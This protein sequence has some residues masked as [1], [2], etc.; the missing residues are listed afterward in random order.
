MKYDIFISY[1]RKDTAVADR[2]CAALDKAG[3]TYF[4]DRQGI[5]GGFE[6]PEVLAQGIMNSKLVLF[7]ASR[8]SY[9]SKCT[10]NEITFAFNEK[11][12]NSLL[13]Y[14]IDGST[15]PM[16]F[17][18]SFAGINCRTLESHP[19]D[20]VLI[21]DLFTL[22][23][24]STI[25]T[26]T[27]APE[28]PKTVGRDDVFDAEEMYRSGVLL[29]ND[30]K[31]AEAVKMLTVAA[32]QGH[33]EA[34]KL[35]GNFYFNGKGVNKDYSEAFKWSIKS[36]EQGIARAQFNVGFCYQF[37]YG[38]TIDYE[39]SVN[40]YMKAAKQGDML[41]QNALG[42]CY[43]NGKGVTRDYAMAVEWT[44]KAAE[45]GLP[46]AQFNLGFF[47]FNGYGVT[48]NFTE[49]INWFRKSAEQGNADAQ[50]YLGI[51]Y[52]GGDGVERSEFEAVKWFRKAAEQG[53]P[54][55]QFQLGVCYEQA[56]G[57]DMDIAEAAKWYKKAAEQGDKDAIWALEILQ[58]EENKINDKSFF[59]KITSLFR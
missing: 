18:F 13:P 54:S 55:A 25:V 10:I 38:V 34:Q 50:N 20:T 32:V 8:N 46:K 7:L 15:M 2:I 19:I 40:W 27:S 58:K 33:A 51:C 48:K 57:L 52:L 29:I 36:A 39:S 53:L 21:K 24:R 11:P 28:S 22:L 45:Q 30:K 35:L 47:Y 5:A 3:I 12:K 41:A 37:G 23:G 14:I 49:G 26:P 44:K 17:R 1:S 4:I 43:Y 59:S 56:I 6:F 16:K 42:A 9:E 31:Y